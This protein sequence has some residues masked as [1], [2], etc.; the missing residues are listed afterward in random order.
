MY[1]LEKT[2]SNLKELINSAF[3]KAAEKNNILDVNSPKF[4][5]EIPANRSHGDLS[6]NIAMVSAKSF[7]MPPRKIAEEI[8][9]FLKSDSQNI[10][11]N[12]AALKIIGF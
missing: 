11:K 2:I 6:T 8:L 9:E 7:K 5:V 4:E 12:V 1:N 10:F 3:L